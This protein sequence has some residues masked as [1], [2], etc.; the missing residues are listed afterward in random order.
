MK[1]WF[2]ISALVGLLAAVAGWGFST[3]VQPVTAQAPILEAVLPPTQHV[4]LER[5]NGASSVFNEVLKVG[6][7]PTGNTQ[8][9]YASAEILTD[10]VYYRN[11]LR[12]ELTRIPPQATVLQAQLWLNVERFDYGY[13]VTPAPGATIE[14]GVYPVAEPWSPA[15][16]WTW[17]TQPR[18]LTDTVAHTPLTFGQSGGYAVDVTPLVQAWLAGRPNYGVMVGL[19]PDPDGVTDFTAVI[20]G[21]APADDI[22]YPRLVVTYQEPPTKTVYMPL[23]LSKVGPDLVVT[24]I[25]LNPLRVSIANQGAGDAGAFW[26]DVGVDP[27]HLPVVNEVWHEWGS[28][29]GAAWQVPAL[30]GGDAL[31]LTL[32]DA[33][34]QPTQSRW[35]A[36]FSAGEHRLWAY[37]DSWGV[38]YPWGGVQ[39]TAEDNNRYGPV[40]FVGAAT[41]PLVAPQQLTPIPPRTWSLPRGAR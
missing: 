8:V 20:H 30:R 36:G 7:L 18:F 32:N 19:S 27:Q 12:F 5:C 6:N 4:S 38:P 13:A 1:P 33:W 22:L 31:T 15:P 2:G 14:C 41:V 21:T 40:S 17:E 23:V 29:Y 11:Y 26:V 3:A 28:P 34:Y 10:T 9:A 16:T 39:E 24:E 25:S 35:P 37:V